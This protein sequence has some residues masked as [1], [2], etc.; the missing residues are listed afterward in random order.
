MLSHG[1]GKTKASMSIVTLS[2]LFWRAQRVVEEWWQVYKA[3][4]TVLACSSSQV[5]LEAVMQS[6]VSSSGQTEGCTV[7]VIDYR[8]LDISL[9]RH[10]RNSC[11]PHIVYADKMLRNAD[12]L[13]LKHAASIRAQPQIAYYAHSVVAIFTDRAYQNARSSI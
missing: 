10:L 9:C 3:A 4:R 11:H 5:A 7:H 2:K 12:D 6:A 8:Q 1:V 13:R